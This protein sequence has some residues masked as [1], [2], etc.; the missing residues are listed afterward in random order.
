MSKFFSIFREEQYKRIQQ[1]V[2]DGDILDIGGS[3]LSGYQELI[4]GNHKIITVNINKEY[5]CDLIFDIEKKFPLESNTFDSV[6]CINT[7]EH[8]YN[9]NNVIKEASRVL[10]SDGQLI[11]TSPFIHHI[12]GSPHDYFRYTKSCLNKICSES[13]FEIIE[14][15]ELGFGLFSLIFQITMDVYPKLIKN[16][17]KRVHLLIDK[18]LLKIFNKYKLIQERNPLGYYLLAKKK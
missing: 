10:K 1:L 9:F 13:G 11:I 17:I 15:S 7:L 6:L 3:K 12:H 4:K 8:I 2:I 14:V 5:G 18:S 16:F